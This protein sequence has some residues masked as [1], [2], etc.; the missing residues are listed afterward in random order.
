[1]LTTPLLPLP[2]GLE[3]TSISEAKEEL[4]V[5]VTSQRDHSCCP[6]CGTVSRTIHSY[7]RR[8]PQ[9]LPCVGR[10]LRLVLTV[11]KFFCRETSCA[12]KIFAERL[13]DLIEVSSRLTKRLR[14]AVQDIG[15][16]TC[17]KGGE[18]LSA[19]LGIE[20][21]D[22]TLLQSLFLIALP[23]I[24]KLEVVGIDDWSYRRG[25][26][27]GSILV[28]LKS[29][30][31]VDLLPD[32]EAES[33]RLWLSAH[34][35]VDIVSRD[36]GAVYV[37]GATRGAPQ[38]IQVCDRWHLC[39]NIGD[40][41]EAFLIRARIRLPEPPSPQTPKQANAPVPLLDSTAT[42][43]QKSG[44]GRWS[45][46]AE[47][48]QQVHELCASGMSLRGIARH[49]GLA[50]NTVRKYFQQEPS[51]L[52]V[53]TPRRP[54]RS[55]LDSYEDYLLS[56]WDQGCRNAALLYR[57]LRAK[58]FRGAESSVRAYITRLRKATANGSPP[59]SRKDHAKAVS[60]RVQRWLLAR[61]RE[62]LDQS[63]QAQL[64]QLLAIS[65]QVQSVYTL[66]QSFLSMVRERK[67]ERLR[68]W[69][70]GALK[71]GI[72]EL[73]SF[74]GGIERDFDAVKAALC[75][76][77]SQGVTEGK[78]NKLKT[79]KRQM[80]GRAGFALLRQRLLYAA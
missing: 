23:P 77:W 55:Q 1:M 13:P 10:P 12:R 15:F 69:M 48:Y 34:P 50:R 66:L 29:H 75:L 59:C 67:P 27:Y 11:K 56:Q 71:S 46:K 63:E 47:L 3:I 58:G 61:L 21:S 44:E 74:V 14:A 60:P 39:K 73:K 25:K 62:D 20:I 35:E 53:P 4:R 5:C 54:R 51:V 65:E 7:Y 16:A 38:A 49:L 6:V 32:R 26:R 40:A 24:G 36:R 19:K 70:E 64:D 42:P 72:S 8:K 18:R 79:I 76:P 22:A 37:D 9:D 57:E 68:P 80:Y 17:G 78:V 43:S 52:P 41:V 28:D 31:I 33:V 45:R 30:K 2:E